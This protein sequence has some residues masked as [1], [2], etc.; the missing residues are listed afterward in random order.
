[1][2][3]VK[4]FTSGRLSN[5]K[6]VD[7]RHLSLLFDIPYYSEAKTDNQRFMNMQKRYIIDN[8]IKALDDMYRLG[9]RVAL[10]MINKFSAANRHIQNLTRMEKSEKA[11]NASSYIIEQYIKRPTFYI[12]KSYTAYLYKRV[13]Y[14]LFYH[15]KIDAAIIYCDMTNALYS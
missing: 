2:R 8:D 5:I 12:K 6:R 7:S 15:R 14:E 3:F 9:I 1:M 13:Q 4:R 11:H 10:K